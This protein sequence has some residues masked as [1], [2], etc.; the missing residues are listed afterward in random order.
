MQIGNI[1][2]GRAENAEA[3]VAD[4]L[5]VS[6]VWRELVSRYEVIQLTQLLQNFAHDT[7]LKLILTKG[8]METLEKQ[9]NKLE[10]EMNKLKIPLP[11][12][13]PKSV[14]VPSTTGIFEDGLIYSL[15][16]NG[17][18]DM[19]ER[20]IQHIRVITTKDGLRKTLIEFLQEEV[21]LFDKMVL[22]GKIK[23]WLKSPPKFTA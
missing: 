2:I 17:I 20:H 22:Y 10:D 1:H 12:R 4:V 7:D 5:E 19:L 9:V 15:V 11:E 3:P 18:Q 6:A 13:P 21:N 16:F 14:K 8:L 23:G